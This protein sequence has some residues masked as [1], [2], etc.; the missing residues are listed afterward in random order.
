MACECRFRPAGDHAGAAMTS[1]RDVLSC[2]PRVLARIFVGVSADIVGNSFT[3]V[4]APDCGKRRYLVEKLCDAGA[5]TRRPGHRA[6]PAREHDQIEIGGAKLVAEEQ[7]AV[8][9][10]MVLD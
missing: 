10:K 5:R 4:G 1:H 7:R 3:L 8:S 6:S 9:P 2:D